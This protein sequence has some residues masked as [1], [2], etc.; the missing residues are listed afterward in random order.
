MCGFLAS[1]DAE[2]D[3]VVICIAFGRNKE[4]V[5]YIK[6][7]SCFPLG[8]VEFCGLHYCR[9]DEYE[10]DTVHSETKKDLRKIVNGFCICMLLPHKIKNNT[11]TQQ[12]ATVTDDWRTM[13]KLGAIELPVLSEELFAEFL[14]GTY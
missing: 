13:G 1:C 8:S 4:H 3:E 9:I 6:V 10:R 7:K 12:F 14:Q 2:S 11:F 5:Q